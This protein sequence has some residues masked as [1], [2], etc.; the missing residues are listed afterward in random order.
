VLKNDVC[1]VC[2]DAPPRYGHVLAYEATRMAQSDSSPRVRSD[3]AC[4]RCHTSWGALGR[5]A[6]P[7]NATGFGIG[8]STCHDPHPQLAAVADNPKSP[9]EPREL[10]ASLLRDFPLPETL[11]NLP[12]TLLG[13]SRVCLGCH[14]PSSRLL[15]PEA[16]A[17]ALLAGQGGRVPQT[18]EPLVLPSPHAAAPKGCLTCHASGPTGLTLGKTHG[19]AVDNATCKSCHQ[20]QPERDGALF[21]RARTL[22]QKLDPQH[23]PGNVAEPWHSRFEQLLPTPERTRALQN[24]LLVLEDP[25]A[26][27]HHPAYAKA[28]LDSAERVALGVSP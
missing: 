28:L 25:A 20:A 1:A 15:R 10:P 27:V 18:G 26:D 2:H 19:F 11:S 9:H 17:A 4:A 16:S 14:A 24:I 7:P 21:A 22:L 8:C 13:P 3:R 12:P 6:P 5:P 23:A